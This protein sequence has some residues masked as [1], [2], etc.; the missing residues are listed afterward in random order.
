MITQQDTQYMVLSSTAG[1]SLF[2]IAGTV[3]IR[4]RRP[5]LILVVTQ[6]AELFHLPLL[7]NYRD[8]KF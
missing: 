8:G 7:N 3:P 5:S 1:L 6:L 4:P 2:S